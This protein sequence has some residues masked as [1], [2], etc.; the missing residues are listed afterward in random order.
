MVRSS[1][2][3]PV[4]RSFPAATRKGLNQ[5]REVGGNPSPGRHIE[6]AARITSVCFFARGR[7]T[8]C[9]CG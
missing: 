8:T 6:H 5:S 4:G 1:Q 9:L 7:F 3:S 2:T